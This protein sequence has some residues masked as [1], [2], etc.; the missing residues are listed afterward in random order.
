[1]KENV[2]TVDS[3]ARYGGEEFAII[4][5]NT[6]PEM[7]MVVGQRIVDNIADYPF[8]MDGQDVQMTISCGMVLYPEHSE[9]MKDLIDIADQTMY[10]TKQ[11]GGNGISLYASE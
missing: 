6:T 9:N 5:I 8:S 4:L 11:S 7:G 2:R 1:M 10:K 3:V